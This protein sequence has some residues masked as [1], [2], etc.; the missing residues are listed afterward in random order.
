M[1]CGA[2]TPLGGYVIGDCNNNMKTT[3]QHTLKLLTLSVVANALFA[4]VAYANNF[5]TEVINVANITFN[6]GDATISIPTNEAV[7]TIE[8]PPVNPTIEFFRYSPN[9]NNPDLVQINGSEF[10]PSGS[11]NG[12]F[13]PIG[14]AINTGSLL[15]V[16]GP[17]PLIPAETYLSGELMFLR[18]DYLTANVNSNLIDTVIVTVETDNNDVITLRLFETGPDTGEFWAY[19]P[20]TSGATPQNDGEITTTN[21]TRLVATFVPEVDANVDGSSSVNVVADV[22][23][24][25]PHNTVFD[26]ITGEPVSGAIVRLIDLDTGQ[27]AEVFGVDGFSE[28][29]ATLTSGDAPVDQSGLIYELDEGMFTFPVVEPGNYAVEVTPPEGYSFASTLEPDQINS[30][31]GA[32]YFV[33]DASYGEAYTLNSVSALRFDIP[34]DPASELSLTKVADRSFADVGDY[35]NYTISIQ[36]Q[37]LSPVPVNLFDSLPRGFSYLE[38]TSFQNDLGISDPRVADNGTD[39]TF[40]LGVLAP[41]ET[42]ELDYALRVGPGGFAF[43]EAVNQ[44]VV[45]DATGNPLSNV[46]RATVKLREDLLRSKSTVV[47]RISEQSC[48]ADQDWARD[49]DI[50]IPVEGVRIYMETGAY[51]VSDEDGLFHFEGVSE[52]THVVQIDEGTLPQGF[53]PMV[54]EENTRYA[55]S[56]ISKFVDVQGGGI[57][58]ANFYLKQTGEVFNDA[59]ADTE[60]EYSDQTEYLKYD[61]DWL[62]GQSSDTEWVYPLETPSIPSANIGIK[63]AEGQSVNIRL[64]GKPVSAL[65]YSGRDISSNKKATISRWR[66]V[67]LRDGENRF[68]ISITDKAGNLVREFSHELHYVTDIDRAIGL[69]DQSIL[70]ADGRTAPEIAIRLEDAAGHGI[71]AG[72]V[73]KVDVVDPYLLERD[74]RLET[75]EDLLGPFSA[76]AE[77]NVGKGGIAKVRL[78][79]TLRTG[80]VTVNVT[81]NSGRIVP[82]YMYLEPEQR[83]WIIVGLAEGSIGYE[84]IRDKSVSLTE[85]LNDTVTDGR[86]AFFAK[87]L[88]KGNWLMTLAVDTDKSRGGRDGDFIEEID[89]NAY[90]T[91]YGDQSY[92]EFEAQSRYPLYVKLEKKSAYALF[93]DFDTDITEGRLTAYNRRLTGLKSEYVGEKFQVLGF[94]AETNQGFALDELAAD[95]TSGTYQL[96]HNHILAQSENIVIETRDRNRPDIILERREMVRFLDYT[97]DYLT[98]ELIFRLPVDA[99]DFDFNPNVIVAE[100]ETS[101]DAERN[102][103]LGGRIQ[104]NILDDKVQIGSSFVSENGSAQTSGSKQNMVGVDLV[105]QVNDNTEVRLEYAITDDKSDSGGTHDAILAEVL[106]TSEK[107]SAEAYFREEEGGFGLGQTGSN[108]NDIRRYGVSAHLKV[109]EFDNEE[110][111]R[112]GQQ[113]LEGTAYHEDNLSTGDSRDTAEIIANHRT[114]NLTVGGGLRIA[115]DEFVNFEDRQSILAIGQASLNFPEKG[116]NLQLAHEQPL[117]GDDEVSAFPQ[118]TSV[119]A[120]KTLGNKA[121]VTVRHDYL[122][123]DN[124]TSNNTTVGVSVTPWNGS[125]ITASSD[126]VTAE[127][128]RRLGATVGL[129]Q[130]IQIDENWTASLGVRNRK[131]LDTEGEFLEVAPDAAISPFEVNED[132]TSAYVGIGYRG[133]VTSASTRL[134]TRQSSES[135]TWIAS[136]AVTREVS[137]DLSVAGALRATQ[138]ENNDDLFDTNQVDARLGLAWRPRDEDLIVFNRFDYGQSQ[139]ALGQSRKK[140]VNNIAANKSVANNWQ[141]SANHGIKY[142]EETIGDQK[143]DGLTNLIGL[144]TRYDITEKID[145]GLRGQA[146]I[147]DDGNMSY[148][149]G[150]SIGLS[151]VDNIWISAGYNVEGYSD[152]DFE[153]AEFSRKGA[154][155]QLRIKFDQNT[156]K[157]LLRKISPGP[158]N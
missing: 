5:G 3:V 96:T 17:V 9:A 60:V 115:K 53:E 140:L 54:C 141:L 58:R 10:S 67:D 149:Y 45:R 77:V 111:G 63:H 22:A 75:R 82:I 76:R 121:S 134:E 84:T 15:N 124:A 35:I 143:F 125:N 26:S 79:P 158:V 132:F 103:T 7:F 55:G 112:R 136:A 154:Y 155:L 68:D 128:S 147:D 59:D 14:P 47:G 122:K 57:W 101:E 86:V 78:E 65:N 98:G 120:T 109:N 119:G 94:A 85:S 20:S 107:L 30:F 2:N 95:G 151:P 33:I 145:L 81:L 138:N 148:S 102:I 74:D 56:A 137:E 1:G 8:P 130:Q 39:L 110:T 37:G 44:A 50:G 73:V 21:N 62:D 32:A 34:L 142:V 36:N 89:P 150:P 25:N 12:P 16:D 100:Y 72:Q 80:K 114:D 118:R 46:G 97:L 24:V 126:L 113:T 90:Y 71:S 41:N 49:I 139:N 108:T 106:H 83:D 29:P 99:T 28:F 92:Q 66:G 104:T 42:I 43:G 133:E 23:L 4:E 144:E 153:A 38:G 48:D 87:G 70:V 117:G 123:G 88:V 18:V 129:D 156:A 93:G 40:N 135:D 27:A 146:L 152:D 61:K 131:L 52:G 11:T 116:I 6:I 157:G 31:T 105:A 69:P 51:A 127:S 64:N 19:L 91:L 13:A